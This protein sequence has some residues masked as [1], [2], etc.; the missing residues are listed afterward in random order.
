MT[1]A[2]ERLRQPAR[3]RSLRLGATTLTYVPDGAVQLSPRGWLPE[4][5]EADWIARPDYLDAS[6]NLAGSIGG[7]LVERSGRSLLIDA[8]FGP[9][10]MPAVPGSPIGTVRSGSLLENLTALGHDPASIESVAFTHLHVD[11]LG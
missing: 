10:S 9:Q 3:I 5:T 1:D 7:L 2:Y 6:G 11:H 8:G 4:T